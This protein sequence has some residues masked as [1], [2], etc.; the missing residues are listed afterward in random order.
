VVESERSDA[1]SGVKA[2]KMFGLKLIDPGYESAS[3]RDS[4]S[5]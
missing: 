4:R 3:V 5:M 2:G 1:D